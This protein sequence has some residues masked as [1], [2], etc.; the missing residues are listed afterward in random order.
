[1]NIRGQKRELK[2]NAANLNTAV[3]KKTE[4]LIQK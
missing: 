3:K 2:V 1:M 4:T